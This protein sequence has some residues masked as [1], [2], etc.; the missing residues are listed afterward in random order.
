MHAQGKTGRCWALGGE[1]CRLPRTRGACRTR[2]PGR[3]RGPCTT[4]TPRLGRSLCSRTQAP[5]RSAL[6]TAP[7]SQGPSR[8]DWVTPPP[9][10]Y[11]P[12]NRTGADPVHLSWRG[13]WTAARTQVYLTW[14]KGA[15]RVRG[16]ESCQITSQ[17]FCRAAGRSKK[18]TKNGLSVEPKLPRPREPV[19]RQST[20]HP[21]P[22]V[23]LYT[24]PH[25]KSTGAPQS[26]T[27]QSLLSRD[28]LQT[29]AP[30]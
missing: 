23:F 30:K 25:H 16:Q 15:D 5:G 13:A 10:G 17:N 29:E 9:L 21:H 11:T 8:T 27:D 19:I 20:K 22:T 14:G 6:L 28:K 4:P 24:N 3:A 26:L 1:A 18:Q 7:A 2:S 12:R